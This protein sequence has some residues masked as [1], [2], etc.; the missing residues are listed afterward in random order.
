M[1]RGGAATVSNAGRSVT[2]VVRASE[3]SGASSSSS[4]SSSTSN[5]LSS[6]SNIL[7][8]D[9]EAE[10]KRKVEEEKMEKELMEAKRERAARL[11]EAAPSSAPKVVKRAATSYDEGDDVS[12]AQRG[13]AAVSYLLPLLDGLKYR[14]VVPKDRLSCL[15]RSSRAYVLGHTTISISHRQ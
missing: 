13:L 11:Q 14:F 9:G 8:E 2:V 6:L 4:P 1:T 15:K 3:E 7:G 5:T 12:A 10:R